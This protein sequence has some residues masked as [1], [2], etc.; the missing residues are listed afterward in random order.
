MSPPT[1][2]RSELRVLVAP[3]AAARLDAARALVRSLPS[4]T[5]VAVVGASRG[6][7]DDFVASLSRGP[8]GIVRAT[9]G[10]HRLTLAGL[11]ARLAVTDLARRGLTPSSRLGI[12]AAAAR[13][14]ARAR[15]ASALGYFEPVADSPNFARA[16]AAT[17]DELR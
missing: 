13:A 14:V 9:F 2:P 3:G 11:A 16:L 1:S 8:A 7:V 12:E 4:S 6:A 5:E 17:L 15:E 10:L